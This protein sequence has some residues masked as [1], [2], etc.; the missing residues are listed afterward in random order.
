MFEDPQTPTKIDRL[1]VRMHI[2]SEGD[3]K[4]EYMVVEGVHG[5]R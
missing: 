1:I 4:I 5:R 3:G 2:R